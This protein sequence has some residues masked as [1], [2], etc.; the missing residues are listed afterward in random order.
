MPSSDRLQLQKLHSSK[1]GPAGCLA[2]LRLD[3]QVR[4]SCYICKLHAKHP[5]R[6]NV[7]LSAETLGG[8]KEPA[9]E[10]LDLDS[11]HTIL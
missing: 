10:E 2:G 3:S 11:K 6:N 9:S 8:A 1:K 5:Q 7:D 4:F